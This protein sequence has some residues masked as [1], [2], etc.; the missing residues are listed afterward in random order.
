MPLRRR[1]KYD[2]SVLPDDFG[3]NWALPNYGIN[4]LDP[5]YA[6]LCVT[7]M[8]PVQAAMYTPT[9]WRDLNVDRVCVRMMAGRSSGLGN[10]MGMGAL[11]GGMGGLGMMGLGNMNSLGL[12]GL[13]NM[14]GLGI[15]GLGGMGGLG[16]MSL[17]GRLGVDGERLNTGARQ[18]TTGGDG[19]GQGE[20][21][22]QEGN[23]ATGEWNGD[24][25][26]QSVP[27]V[28]AWC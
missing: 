5:Y 27:R 4:S 20:H 12:I 17:G 3:T 22:A 13:G 26:A 28:K 6:G 25:G 7:R 21:E 9:G 16:M 1:N 23:E 10:P 15:S 2:L 8:S 19:Q 14:N 18:Q 24:E 11:Y